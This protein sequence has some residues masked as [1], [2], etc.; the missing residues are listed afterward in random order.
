MLNLFQYH[1]WALAEG[2][3]NRMFPT[4]VESV[5]MGHN[6]VKKQTIEDHLPGIEA[7]LYV[8]GKSNMQL[9]AIRRDETS[10]LPV[11]SYQNQNVAII[12]I[13]GA[14][15]KRGELCSYGMQDYQRMINRANA[16]EGVDGI[17]LLMD[18]PGGTVDGTP[19]LGLAIK[20]S[21][22]PVG[23][24]GDAMV[25]S[26]GLWLASQAS[27][28]VGNKNN[29]TEFGS[30]GVLMGLPNYQNVMD[31]GFMPKVKIYRAKQSVDKARVNAVEAITPEAEDELQAELDATGE[32]FINTVKEGR[33]DKLDLSM[34]G[35]FTGQMFGVD[36]SLSGGIIDSVG[37]LG[38]A[39]AMVAALANQKKSINE[40]SKS[41]K[42]AMSK[43]NA[44][45]SF[46]GKKKD[47]KTAPVANAAAHAKEAAEVEAAADDTVPM[48]SEELTFN[49]D[50][51]GDGAFC[52]HPD[53]SGV[54]RKFETK[55]DG[56]KG[57][58]P[59]ADP[60]VKEND[61]WS[62][63]AEAAEETTAAATQE[64]TT[65]AKLNV[66]LKKANAQASELKKQVE[67]LSASLASAQARLE[68]KP[69]GVATTVVAD[70]DAGREV[71]IEDDAKY[72]TSVDAEVAELRKAQALTL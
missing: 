64:L 61:S 11:A 24:F 59:P 68:E 30:I 7:M 12:P 4:V 65:V 33:G 2:Y 32:M 58:E 57:N 69:A 13:I 36:E 21:A 22:K 23:V 53:T 8:D 62:L 66:A 9:S 72:A 19:E 20:N 15:T 44:F 37:T 14:L 45:S 48:W 42:S 26:A 18:T 35:L 40:N 43:P 54:D 41:N 56:N 16:S 46:F 63:V 28:I 29:P 17:V 27:V 50:G 6:L 34:K 38:D 3:F 39:V 60:S 10:G 71:A 47:A 31:A 67:T 25:A 55:T 49:T 5:R 70:K 1:S 51:S 52:L